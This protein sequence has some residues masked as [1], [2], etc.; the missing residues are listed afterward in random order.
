MKAAN[1][2]VLLLLVVLSNACVFGETAKEGMESVEYVHKKIVAIAAELEK[3]IEKC[4]L[5]RANA[6]VP[7]IDSSKLKSWDVDK[8]SIV[9]GLL[10]LSN[11]NFESCEG[12]ARVELA[13][14]LGVL[15]SLGEYYDIELPPIDE[16]NSTLIFPTNRD[17]SAELVFNKLPKE[18]KVY[19]LDSVG[20]DPFDL[21]RTVA[22][23]KILD[24]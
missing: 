21:L 22:E 4:S 13:Y 12:G 1:R 18:V 6:K 24:E 20:N 14:Q 2:I 5:I 16:I 23:N 10:Y 8:Q 17:I 3:N 11:R 15:K 19:I 9:N 7:K